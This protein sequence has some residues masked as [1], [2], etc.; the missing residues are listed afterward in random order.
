MI[1]R[2]VVGRYRWIKNKIAVAA[3]MS[4]FLRSIDDFANRVYRNV[5]VLSSYFF[6]LYYHLYIIIIYVSLPC[7]S[8]CK[9]NE[10]I[11]TTI[12]MQPKMY[13]VR[14]NNKNTRMYRQQEIDRRVI[15]RHNGKKCPP[16]DYVGMTVYFEIGTRVVKFE[17][18]IFDQREVEDHLFRK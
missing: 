2:R 5:F 14:Y 4:T 18:V 10:I 17:M 12:C 13:Y 15:E 6:L 16:T 9:Y 1:G 7:I 3:V 8:L 11:Y